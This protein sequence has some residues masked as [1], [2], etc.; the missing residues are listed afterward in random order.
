VQQIDV[1]ARLLTD[2]PWLCGIGIAGYAAAIVA[3]DGIGYDCHAYWLA[4]RGDLY[5]TAPNTSGA[6]LYSPAFA[7]AIWPLA[8]LPWPAFCTVWLAMAGIVI[9]LLLRP[10]GWRRAVPLWLCCTPE[11]VN[12]NVFWLFA[13]VA[14][15]GLRRP[16]LWLVPALTKITPALGP[17]WFLVRREWRQLGISV[18]ATL[19]V[20]GVSF[21]IDPTAWYAWFEFL[22]SHLGETTM[23]VGG[24]FVPPVVRIPLAVLLVAWGAWRDRR[25]VLPV[26][27]V[28]A[29]PVFGSAALAVLAGLPIL[30]ATGSRDDQP[31]RP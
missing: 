10:L 14:A 2:L 16:W 21:A 25:W 22:R 28:L 3:N 18:L 29:N 5:T 12:G 30:L 24:L 15:F 9:A 19:A 4:A 31:V 13:V 23:Q 11:I 17:V 8:Q 1:R 26:A 7:Q 6:Y 20:A 27:M